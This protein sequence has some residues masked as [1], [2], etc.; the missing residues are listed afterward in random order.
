MCVWGGGGRR[1]G[2]GVGAGSSA[3]IFFLP[4]LFTHV[5]YTPIVNIICHCNLTILHPYRM[6]EETSNL[7][8][9]SNVHLVWGW[10]EAGGGARYLFHRCAFT[11]VK[12]WTQMS[13]ITVMFHLQKIGEGDEQQ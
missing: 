3:S 12:R 7:Q 5:K 10:G 9:S 4:L 2:R 13:L 6:R 11:L 1:T 8:V